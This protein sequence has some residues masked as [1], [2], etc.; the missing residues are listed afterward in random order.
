MSET[1]IYTAAYRQAYEDELANNHT[2]DEAHSLAMGH[3]LN[4][5]FLATHEEELEELVYA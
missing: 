3:A 5:H 2:P 4:A 1:D